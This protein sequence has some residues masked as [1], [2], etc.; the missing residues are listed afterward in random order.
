[1]DQVTHGGLKILKKQRKTSSKEGNPSSAKY[2]QN[3][4]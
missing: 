3:D 4:S 1:M 2:E